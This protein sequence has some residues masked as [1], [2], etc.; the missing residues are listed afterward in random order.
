[1]DEDIKLALNF[2]GD[3]HRKLLQHC[4]RLVEVS[5]SY[6]NRFY[7]QWD[8]NDKTIRGERVPDTADQ[9]ARVRGE[10]AKLTMPFT[11]AQ[12]QTFIAFM[13]S[14][15]NQRAKFFEVEDTGTEDNITPETDAE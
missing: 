15:F 5:R 7:D 3:F 13:M 12:T 6:M 11:Y 4:K 14:L 8:A 9:K 2:E 1:M 10:P